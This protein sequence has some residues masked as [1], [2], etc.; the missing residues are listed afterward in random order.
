MAHNHEVPGSSPGPATK[1]KHSPL[2][3]A[4]SLALAQASNLGLAS[5]AGVVTVFGVAELRKKSTKYFSFMRSGEGKAAVLVP[6][7]KSA[8]PCAGYLSW[9]RAWTI[10]DSIVGLSLQR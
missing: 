2:V 10:K 3:G 4:F 8:Q 7:P 9:L 6:Q 1:K 5:I